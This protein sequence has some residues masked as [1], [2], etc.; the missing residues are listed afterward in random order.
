MGNE[1]TRTHWAAVTLQKYFRMWMAQSR[2]IRLQLDAIGKSTDIDRIV[3]PHQSPAVRSFCRLKF[4]YSGQQIQFSGA[5]L[6]Q[7]IGGGRVFF[8]YVTA[9]VA[10]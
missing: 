6:S 5:V 8:L 7:N 9:S 4:S 2:L 3:F 10:G 1:A